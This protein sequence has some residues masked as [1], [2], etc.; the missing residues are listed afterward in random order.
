[1]NI[2]V[3]EK[4]KYRFFHTDATESKKEE[5]QKKIRTPFKLKLNENPEF[6][7]VCRSQFALCAVQA[8]EI[9]FKQKY[10]FCCLLAFIKHIN[11]VYIRWIM[12]G[13]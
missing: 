7:A 12:S 3:N 6:V 13:A 9:F 10:G 8:C 11:S 2:L 4:E 5:L 1:M